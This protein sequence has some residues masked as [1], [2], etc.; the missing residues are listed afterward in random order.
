M[1]ASENHPEPLRNS[2]RT[3]GVVLPFRKLGRPLEASFH[4]T[5]FGGERYAEIKKS[6][7]IGT[8]VGLFDEV[9][10]QPEIEESQRSLFLSRNLNQGDLSEVSLEHNVASQDFHAKDM[11]SP[12]IANG[13]PNESRTRVFAVKGRCP[14]PL[15]DGDFGDPPWART[16][17][18]LLKREMLYRLS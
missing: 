6:V 13:V 18:P 5:A 7:G 16:M 14:G 10:H 12:T 1:W 4:T 3:T 8:Y 11:G 2:S 9:S 15:D 17:D